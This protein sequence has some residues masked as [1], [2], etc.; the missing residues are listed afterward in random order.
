MKKISICNIVNTVH[1]VKVN[2]QLILCHFDKLHNLESCD[3]IFEDHNLQF[4]VK[5]KEQC[6]QYER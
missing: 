5:R 4:L 2:A 3:T 6:L 1:K